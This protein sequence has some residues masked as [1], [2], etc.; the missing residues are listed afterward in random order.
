M[1]GLRTSYTGYDIIDV[2][3][4]RP[5]GWNEGRTVMNEGYVKSMDITA[6]AE[7]CRSPTVRERLEMDRRYLVANLEKINGAIA[8]LD[9]NPEVAN[10]L[11]ILGKAGY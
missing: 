3:N 1:Y 6:R 8:A 4:N 9:A 11:E 5:L 2:P 7:E 10:V